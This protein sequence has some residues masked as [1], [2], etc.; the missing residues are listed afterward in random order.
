MTLDTF[1]KKFGLTQRELQTAGL[2]ALGCSRKEISSSLG[3]SLSAVSRL[4]SHVREKTG[5]H[6]MMH[7]ATFCAKN[8]TG[9]L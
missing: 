2:L 5:R 9:P 6:S 8:I 7:V 1:Q 3:V 4:V